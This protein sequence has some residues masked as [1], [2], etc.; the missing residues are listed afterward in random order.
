MPDVVLRKTPCPGNIDDWKDIVKDPCFCHVC[1]NLF[2]GSAYSISPRPDIFMHE[3]TGFE[4][5]KAKERKAY[6]QGV[7]NDGVNVPEWAGKY[8]IDF[9]SWQF[10]AGSTDLR[11]RADDGCPSCWILLNGILRLNETFLSETK[12]E[13]GQ[14]FEAV[15][16][17]CKENVLRA[18]IYPVEEDAADSM[19]GL[20]D[21]PERTGSP[22]MCCEFYTLPDAPCP[23]PTIGS[24]MNLENPAENGNTWKG[25]STSHIISVPN[26]S[27]YFKVI[28]KWLI[29]CDQNH[30]SCHDELENNNFGPLPKRVIDVGPDDNSGIHIVEHDDKEQP[31]KEPYIALSHCW[32]LTQHTLSLKGTIGNWKENIPWSKLRKTFREAIT[33]TRRLGIQYIWIDSLCII[34]DD[35]KDWETEA[36]KMGS[37]Y[38]RAYLVIAATGSV[39]GDGGIFIDKV[40]Y[41]TL[42]GEDQQKRR[43]EIYVRQQLSHSSFSWGVSNIETQRATRY[44]YRST[45][46]SSYPLFTRAWCFQERLL[47]SRVLHFTREELIFECITSVSCECGALADFPDDWVLP[48]RNFVSSRHPSATSSHL[49][50]H[51]LIIGKLPE[52][53]IENAIVDGFSLFDDWRDLVSE[54]SERMITRSSDWLP[55]LAGLATKWEYPETGR[56]LAGLWTKD[57]L[58][59]LLWQSLDPDE[60]DISAYIAPSWSWANTH[61]S[62]SWISKFPK[63]KYYVEIDIQR[64]DCVPKGLNKYGELT[65]GWLFVTGTVLEGTL[66]SLNSPGTR[67]QTAF[68]ETDQL[69]GY[70][71]I[72]NRALCSELIGQKV[73][74]LRYCTDITSDSK[75]R[76]DRALILA[77]IP[78]NKNFSNLPDDIRRFPNVYRRIGVQEFCKIGQWQGNTTVMS[79]YII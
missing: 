34:Q 37:I 1:C 39:D 19:F 43:F 59:G 32:G 11:S 26:E 57:L 18:L 49:S 20:M 16:V 77:R 21:A 74:C 5:A 7:V 31:I 63:T 22:V 3:S 67:V 54:Y 27:D 66:K 13:N 72:D 24:S 45:A 52:V 47:G 68:F 71:S 64:T 62:V 30:P 70:F 40:P 65:A 17:F 48:S 12:I 36:A 15:F 9:A 38:N 75:N 41:V 35:A 78:G 2:A 46:D 69:T 56:Y 79:M 4:N 44:K 73:L 8:R 60:S 76:F 50:Q 61:H 14:D 58:R 10:T 51:D 6:E 42:L 29:N 55:A 23:W 33:M 53:T 28:Q 25:S